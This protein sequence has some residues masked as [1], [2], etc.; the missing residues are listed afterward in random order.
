MEKVRNEYREKV[1]KPNGIEGNYFDLRKVINT[2]VLSE[3]KYLTCCINESLRI[4]PPVYFS[5]SNMMTET[6]KVT[7]RNG[8]ELVLEAG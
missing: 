3:L 5:S 7:D 8:K 2:E 4:E 1:L 6:V